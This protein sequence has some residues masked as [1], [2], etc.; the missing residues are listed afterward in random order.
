VTLYLQGWVSDTE[1]I[2]ELANLQKQGASEKT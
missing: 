1:F 2:R